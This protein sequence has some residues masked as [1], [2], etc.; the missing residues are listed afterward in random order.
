MNPT[1]LSFQLPCETSFVIQDPLTN[2]KL[3]ARAASPG[4]AITVTQL[5]KPPDTLP[6]VINLTFLGAADRIY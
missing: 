3:Q 2:E 4:H 6:I 5:R 1:E